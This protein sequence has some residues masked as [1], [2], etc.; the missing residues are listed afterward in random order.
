MSKKYCETLKPGFYL[1]NGL[2]CK[3]CV[4]AT[5][6]T[7]GNKWIDLDVPN[8]AWM[9]LMWNCVAKDEICLCT[10]HETNPTEFILK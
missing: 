9:T 7:R 10:Y 1:F 2:H 8:P 3:R 6:T 4:Y 5:G